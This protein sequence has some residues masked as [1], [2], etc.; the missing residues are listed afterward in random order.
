MTIA[1]NPALAVAD[2]V[3]RGLITL[4]A[5]WITKNTLADAAIGAMY[6]SSQLGTIWRDLPGFTQ[7]SWY[8]PVTLDKRETRC[9]RWFANFT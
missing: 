2:S 7:A 8:M 9:G 4:V 3:I 5:K 6:C 1:I